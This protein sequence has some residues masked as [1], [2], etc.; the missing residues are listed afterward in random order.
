MVCGMGEWSITHAAQSID[1]LRDRVA[2]LRLNS[3]P[4]GE[5]GNSQFLLPMKFVRS[6]ISRS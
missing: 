3:L 4:K 6:R 2:H 5:G 1:A